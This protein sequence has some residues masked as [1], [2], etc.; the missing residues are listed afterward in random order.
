M[1]SPHGLGEGA[2]ILCLLSSSTKWES[3]EL[4]HRNVSTKLCEIIR[5]VWHSWVLRSWKVWVFW[6][7][8]S[9]IES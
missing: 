8:K 1:Y 5:C 3:Q 2:S 6:F 7:M 4:P 9:V